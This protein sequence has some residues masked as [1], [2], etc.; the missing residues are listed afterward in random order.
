MC[1]LGNQEKI[2]FLILVV[3]NLFFCVFYNLPP[4]RLKTKLFGAEVTIVWLFFSYVRL[5]HLLITR[6]LSW[7]DCITD[8]PGHF[9]SIWAIFINLYVDTEEDKRDGSF[10]SAIYLGDTVSKFLIITLPILSYSLAI[11]NALKNNNIYYCLPLLSVPMIFN[12]IALA[13]KKQKKA[14]PGYF[15]FLWIFN[16]LSAV[17]ILLN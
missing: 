8:F 5:P 10:S 16:M 13:L 11:N 3:C 15:K 7:I 9:L 1:S 14:K 12:V 2:H 4:L 6:N 17:G